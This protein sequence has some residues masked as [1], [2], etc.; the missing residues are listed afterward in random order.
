MPIVGTVL[1]SL[2]GIDTLNGLV[3]LNAHGGSSS[4]VYNSGLSDFKKHLPCNLARTARLKQ[5][6]RPTLWLSCGYRWTAVRTGTNKTDQRAREVSL[7]GGSERPFLTELYVQ[8]VGFLLDSDPKKTSGSAKPHAIP[9]DKVKW[10]WI[11]NMADANEHVINL[12]SSSGLR[13]P[14][15]GCLDRRSRKGWMRVS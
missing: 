6:I 5:F 2:L 9:K 7:T 1:I 4:R 10:D 11:N 12:R 13:E 8:Q 15:L 3:R 14:G